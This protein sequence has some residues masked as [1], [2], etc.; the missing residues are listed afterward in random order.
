ML[1]SPEA[2]YWSLNLVTWLM[3]TTLTWPCCPVQKLTFRFTC[4]LRNNQLL[5]ICCNKT[6]SQ[7]S[8]TAS[9][10]EQ[11]AL[12]S[13][14]HHILYFLPHISIVQEW[15]LHWNMFLPVCLQRPVWLLPEHRLVH[16]HPR[17]GHVQRDPYLRHDKRHLLQVRPRWSR[18]S[19]PLNLPTSIMHLQQSRPVTALTELP[20]YISTALAWI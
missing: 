12:R 6:N 7:I 15:K 2:E 10:R 9:S 3:L 5:S 14:N 1:Q 4:Q 16:A 8:C 20:H 19:S 17:H 11:R 13:Q 18:S